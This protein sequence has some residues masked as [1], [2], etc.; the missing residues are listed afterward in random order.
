MNFLSPAT[1]AEALCVPGALDAALE[2]GE[3]FAEQ[4]D[5]DEDRATGADGGRMRWRYAPS[6]VVAQH[7][8]LAP[9]S[10]FCLRRSCRRA[11]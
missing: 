7:S 4:V 6:P 2:A 9:R 8:T 11:P 1:I 10:A 5:R 3:L